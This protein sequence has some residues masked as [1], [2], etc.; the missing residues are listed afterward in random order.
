MK[1]TTLH[2]GLLLAAFIGIFS[3]SITSCKKIELFFTAAERTEINHQ[4]KGIRSENSLKE[5]L[6]K[7]ENNQDEYSDNEQRLNKLTQLTALRQL[8][9]IQRNESRFDDALQTYNR[10]LELAVMMHDTTEQIQALNN[11]GTCYRRLSKLELAIE[12]HYS[13][14][15]IC[16]QKILTDTS[17]N[18]RKSRVVSL[19]GLGNIYLTQGNFL[20][21]DS[22]FR[23]ALAGERQLG[24]SLGQAINY[25]NIGSIFEHLGK[26]DSAWVYYQQSMQHNIKAKSQVG[27]GLCHISF[28][29]LYKKDNNYQKALEEY[30]TAYQL[31]QK[32]KDEWHSLVPLLAMA[33]LTCDMKNFSQASAYLKNAEEI[34][35]RIHST[36]HLAEIYQLYYRIHESLGNYQQALKCHVR[37]VA[38]QDSVVNINSI[39]ESQNTSLSIERKRKV[40]ELEAAHKLY[41]AEMSAKHLAITLF[42]ILLLFALTVVALMLYTMRIRANSHRILQQQSKMREMFFT[43]VTH[44]FRTPLTL[45]LGLSHSIQTDETLPEKTQNMG[46]TIERQGNNLLKLINQLLYISKVKSEVGEPDWRHGNISAYIG[47]IIEEYTEYA[48]SKQ[49]KL[50]YE[51]YDTVHMD[52]VPDYV[53]KVLNNLLSNAF[54]FTPQGGTIIVSLEKEK[55]TI[56]IRI[57]D[58]GMGI[59]KEDLPHLFDPFIQAKNCSKLGTGVG[60]ALVRQII[61]SVEGNIK[62]ESSLGKGTAF[63]M[64]IPM[65]HGKSRWELFRNE[66]YHY[67]MEKPAEEQAK[68]KDYT[69]DHSKLVDDETVGKLNLLIVEDNSDVADYIGS[70]LSENYYVSYAANGKEGLSKAHEQV[71]DLIITDLM[72]PEMDGLEMCRCI[73]ADEVVSHVPIIIVTARVTEAERI[74]GLEAG[75]DAYLC[76]PFNE[77]ELQVRVEKLLEQ[78]RLLRE[79]YSNALIEHISD[80][81]AEKPTALP[82]ETTSTEVAMQEKEAH[83]CT[84]EEEVSSTSSEVNEE[85]LWKQKEKSDSELYNY[86]DLNT[87]FLEKVVLSTYELMEKKEASVNSLASEL[88]MSTRQFQRK[89]VAI[90][91]ETPSTYIMQIRIKRAKELFKQQP[92][93]TI[94]QVAY[95]CGFEEASNF[96]RTFKKFCSITPTQY[97]NKI[98]QQEEE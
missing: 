22:A 74:K 36:E 78:R 14:W 3:A 67:D 86:S 20:R 52:F 94:N 89:I 7:I 45:I 8:G 66:E 9:K 30:H 53:N 71:P 28:G 85:L 72:M 81:E 11:I 37:A 38:L 64:H 70:K 46:G 16:E 90:T 10:G 23:M 27:I 47:M 96:S 1:Y 83:L 41:E 77:D 63:T 4:I 34:A 43:N 59:P 2:G 21:A 15:R 25:A 88:C 60:L 44:E 79:K 18:I 65:K 12:Y 80:A 87:K 29:S 42:A 48:S 24:S 35:Q 19:N 95:E 76:K 6:Q 50:I 5:L 39:N 57:S 68:P 91:G 98:R 26:N 51:N 84:T 69:A 93:L 40:K 92:D 58:T 55:D 49:I 32:L 75:A 73:R 31:M 13:A 97:I 82:A 17:T 54:K 61:T 33:D 62:V 56:C